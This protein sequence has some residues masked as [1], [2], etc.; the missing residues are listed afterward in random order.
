MI[1]KLLC[2]IF[3]HRLTLQE[4]V[5]TGNNALVVTTKCSR[6]PHIQ[7]LAFKRPYN[8]DEIPF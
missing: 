5:W 8:W 1:S 7:Q 6:C 3:G 2:K 4:P